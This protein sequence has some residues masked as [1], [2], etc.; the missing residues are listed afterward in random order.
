MKLDVNPGAGPQVGGVSSIQQGS[1]TTAADLNEV[2]AFG[3][4]ALDTPGA[5]GGVNTK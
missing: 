4:R 1:L 5:G 3:Q 2:E